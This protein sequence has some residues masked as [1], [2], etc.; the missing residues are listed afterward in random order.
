MA[1][2]Q[3]DYGGNGAYERG[4]GGADEDVKQD[5]SDHLQRF[6]W[7]VQP[8]DEDV[9]PALPGHEGNNGDKGGDEEDVEYYSEKDIP[10]SFRFVC[11]LTLNYE[12]V[13]A[14]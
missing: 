2:Y 12:S 13:N 9:E 6:E 8:L 4:D 5:T 14:V 11:H 1:E 10:A 3:K 7:P